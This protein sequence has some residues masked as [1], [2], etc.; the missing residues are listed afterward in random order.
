MSSFNF[1][2]NFFFPFVIDFYAMEELGNGDWH[3]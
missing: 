2:V 1:G 3:F